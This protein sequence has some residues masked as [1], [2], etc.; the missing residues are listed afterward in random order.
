MALIT[1]IW[2]LAALLIL[3]GGFAAMAHSGTRIAR[4]Y[5]ELARAGWAARAGIRRAEAMTTQLVAASYTDLGGTALALS[6]ADDGAELADAEYETTVSDEA[7]KLS[8]NTATLD[9]LAAFFPTDT[10][11]AI[12]DWRD[13]D[14]AV[15]EQGAEDDY[16]VGLAPPYHCKNAPFETVDELLQV[17]GVTPE[18]LDETVTEDGQTL[19]DLLT[20]CSEDR[21][22]DAEGQAR[23]NITTATQQQWTQEF[24]SVLTAQ[25]IT[26]IIQQNTSSA[27]ASPAELLRVPGVTR[28]KLAQLYDRLTATTDRTRPGLVNLNTAPVEVLAVL[29]GMDEVAAQAI[30]TYRTHTGPL[31]TVGD[32]LAIDGISD[33]AF[34]QMADR[35][36]TRSQ[37]F[38][39][40]AVGSTPGGITK[41]ITCILQNDG[42]TVHT[43]YWRE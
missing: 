11:A 14:S 19:R 42:T 43:L 40:V 20:V 26:A 35:V 12:I 13:E 37:R 9:E 16:Y 21:N 30:D 17:K 8:L 15:T 29:P 39:A 41:T 38:R 1:A 25:D 2:V 5:G 3:L 24:G 34:L 28:E 10:A 36:T 18:L 33:A 32:L 22:T 27:F 23:F 4:N 6:S 7:G 31:E